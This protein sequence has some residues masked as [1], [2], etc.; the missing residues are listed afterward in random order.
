MS[1]VLKTTSPVVSPHA[2]ID[3]PVNTVPSASARRAWA[4]SGSSCGDKGRLRSRRG[5]GTRSTSRDRRQSGTGG[6]NSRCSRGLERIDCSVLLPAH[7]RC[8]RSRDAL[9]AG[10]ARP[11]RMPT[12][13][14]RGTGTTNLRR[15]SQSC[16]P[17]TFLGRM[18]GRKPTNDEPR[19]RGRQ[20]R[21]TQPRPSQHVLAA[22]ALDGA[23][24]PRRLA[25]RGDRHRRD[26]GRRDELH[27]LHGRR[28]RLHL[29]DRE[30]QELGGRRSGAARLH[31]LHGADAVAADR[32]R[33]RYAQRRRS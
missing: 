8:S 11:Y 6:C 21:R 31:V 7:A 25:G 9:K 20:R 18:H 16:H 24:G 22:R 13:C 32:L 28:V 17:S 19:L 23:H 29:R 27:R 4:W 1:A 5:T 12:H 33:A 30:D 2:P 15:S 26:D 14:V 10:A 3:L